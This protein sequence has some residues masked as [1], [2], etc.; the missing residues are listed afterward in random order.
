MKSILFTSHL[1]S[2]SIYWT[3]RRLRR[4]VPHTYDVYWLYDDSK[5]SPPWIVRSNNYYTYSAKALKG[6][7]YPFTIGDSL[8]PGNN[9]FPVI[10]FH[11]LHSGYTHYWIVE[12]DV[13]FTGAWSSFF[14]HFENNTADLLSAAITRHADA[15]EFVF[16]NS[17]SH[18]SK[19]IAASKQ[20]RSFNPIYRIS[21]EALN[22]ID[23]AHREGWSG[24]HEVLLPTLLCEN[25]FTIEDFGGEGAFVPEGREN[26]F[27]TSEDLNKFG[28]PDKGTHRYQPRFWKAGS[29]PNKIYHPVKPVS[30]FA[31]REARRLAQMKRFANLSYVYRKGKERLKF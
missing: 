27:Y 7:G 16:W 11:R 1:V 22:F 2:P 30:W 12:Y 24:H 6:K 4:A 26:T 5:G 15:P 8:T 25:G 17:L 3:Y 28:I 10:D 23:A 19:N 20:I 9:H 29:Q 13:R 18:P 21:R 14:N 31:K